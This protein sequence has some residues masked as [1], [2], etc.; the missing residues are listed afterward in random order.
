MNPGRRP[1]APDPPVSDPAV[2]DPPVSGPVQQP[3]DDVLP[4]VDSIRMRQELRR[5]VR[6]EHV[7]E[8]AGPRSPLS[9]GRHAR[10]GSE[11]TAPPRRPRLDYVPRHSVSTPG[12][13]AVSAS[14]ATERFSLPGTEPSD[15]V[16]PRL[17]EPPASEPGDAGNGTTSWSSSQP[18]PAPPSPAPPSGRVRAAIGPLQSRTGVNGTNGLRTRPPAPDD[19]TEEDDATQIIDLA[20]MTG[21]TETIITG[22]SDE[23]LRDGAADQ[24]GDEATGDTEWDGGPDT[25]AEE[26]PPGKR[27]RVVLSQRK[28]TAPRPVRTVVDVQE[29]TQVG[30]LLS[31]SLIRSQLSLALRIG[32]IAAIAL[33][34]WPAVFI[35]FPALGR[36]ELF[37]LRLPWLVLGVL[38]YPFM[39]GLGYLHARSAEKLEQVFADHIQN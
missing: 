5:R 38:A 15:E 8:I 16:R 35:L 36:L 2:S 3:D 28:G 7:D 34:A 24:L 37:G 25:S 22:R 33:G 20:A 6:A 9:G 23:R 10:R 21:E 14:A 27:V 30:E 31:T 17:P 29:L 11:G 13:S 26:L 12:P 4:D 32:G 19:R 1:G 39:L 18:P